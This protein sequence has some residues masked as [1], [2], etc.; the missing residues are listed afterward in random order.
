MSKLF[1]IIIKL[2]LHDYH[3][4][5]NRTPPS[6]TANVEIFAL[7]IF[8]RNSRFSNISEYM[9]IVKI[10]FIMPYRGNNIKCVQ[11]CQVPEI[12]ENLYK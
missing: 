5:S 7:Y 11:N 6:H 1:K 3:V 8:S 10:T 4:D 2:K 9:Y 12:R